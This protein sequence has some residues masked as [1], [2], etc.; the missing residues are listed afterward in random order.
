MDP[1]VLLKT[2]PKFTS[3][4]RCCD[5]S[6][7]FL[8]PR[9]RLFLSPVLKTA[10]LYWQLTTT[11]S[12][13]TW[14]PAPRRISWGPYTAAKTLVLP[15]TQS[16]VCSLYWLIFT[17]V[18]GHGWRVGQEGTFDHYLSYNKISQT[19]CYKQSNITFQFSF[20]CSFRWCTPFCSLCC[21]LKP[22]FWWILIGCWK[23]ST[24]QQ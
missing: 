21:T 23:F 17:Q 3:S 6:R 14:I 1:H 22:F 4:L 24:N 9:G 13:F 10:M 2:L 16:Q 11:A 15:Y 18:F 8:S 5:I 7:L 12:V 19:K 20:H